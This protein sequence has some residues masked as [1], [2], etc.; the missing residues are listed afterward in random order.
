M[1]IAPYAMMH[2]RVDLV[3]KSRY[4]P[5]VEAGEVFV[6]CTSS[7]PPRR[8]EIIRCYFYSA[9][10]CNA[11]LGALIGAAIAAVVA[12]VAAI[13]VVL[14]ILALIGGC[15]TGILCALGVIA[16]AA[17]VA[18]AITMVG[19]TVGGLIGAFASPTS[20]PQPTATDT[21]GDG[22]QDTILTDPPPIAVGDF[23]TVTGMVYPRDYDDGANV[24]WRLG[25][26]NE[27]PDQSSS[28]F[29]HGNA[30][31]GLATPFS[32]LDIDDDTLFPDGCPT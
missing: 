28:V 6:H 29:Q 20:S 25:A 8:A 4:W 19:A 9:E 27:P 31:A 17:L 13:L 16:A 1:F 3:V 22:T 32:H 21:D 30:A 10:V 15:S 26:A 5:F 18:F 12:V 11:G 23:L 14:A 7:L 2:D 24:F